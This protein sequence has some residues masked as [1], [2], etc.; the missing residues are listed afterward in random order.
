MDC[1][2]SFSNTAREDMT[3]CTL[4][5][6]LCAVNRIKE[7]GFCGMGAFPV[8]ARTARHFG[9]EPCLAGA[10]GSG[11]VFFSGCSL[12]CVFCQN[13]E[14]S[15]T[16]KGE[17]ITPERL[18][19]LFEGLQNEGADNID[20]VTPTHFAPLVAE[21]LSLFAPKKK[22]PVVYNSSGYERA[23]TIKRY[24]ENVDI[25]LP[26]LKYVSSALSARYSGA[27]DYFDRAAE[28]LDVMLEAAGYPHFE[29]D[30]MVSGVLI[31]HMVLPSH[32]KDSFAVIDYLAR[33]YDPEKLYVSFLC[34]Y[35][36]TDRAAEYPEINRRLT[37]L[38]YRRVID[39]ALKKGI[40]HGFSQE[41][42]AAT[43]EYVPIFYDT[44]PT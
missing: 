38:E 3:H 44:L 24:G 6:R 9:E 30:R 26:D 16:E 32:I 27:P 40:R 5:P 20:L 13:H 11:A 43:E 14:I 42:S 31:R 7:R 36:P 29:S 34:Q 28:A 37:T 17:V 2:H 10:G 18:C 35:F 23:E 4:C 41:R 39:Y 1:K 25:F 15:H 12:R 19:A 8:V 22:I 21:A 33:R